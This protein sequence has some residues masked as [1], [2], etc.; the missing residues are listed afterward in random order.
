MLAIL[1]PNF[2]LFQCLDVHT[3][4]KPDFVTNRKV[5]NHAMRLLGIS[6]QYYVPDLDYSVDT[7]YISTL[8]N[9]D[10]FF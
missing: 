1:L 9:I 8:Y 10:A 2:P 3:E 7:V 4:M 5:L 6:Q